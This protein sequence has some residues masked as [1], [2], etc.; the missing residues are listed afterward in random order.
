MNQ[1]SLLNA[2]KVARAAKHRQGEDLRV[3]HERVLVLVSDGTRAPAVTARAHAVIAKWESAHTCSP[4]YVEEWRRILADP[5]E[6]LRRY[7][8]RPDAPTALR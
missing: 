7:V 5:V 3:L 2:R 1:S 4:F 8:L 6:G